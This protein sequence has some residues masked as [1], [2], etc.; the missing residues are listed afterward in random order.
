MNPGATDAL[1]R[2][3]RM[4]CPGKRLGIDRGQVDQA[5]RTRSADL[6]IAGAR[7]SYFRYTLEMR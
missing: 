6:M 1:A 4:T 5:T 3:I 7:F 2:Q